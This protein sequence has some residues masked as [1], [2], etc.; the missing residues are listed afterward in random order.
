MQNST[1]NWFVLGNLKLSYYGKDAIKDELQVI[2][3]KAKP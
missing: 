3:D 2:V 1:A